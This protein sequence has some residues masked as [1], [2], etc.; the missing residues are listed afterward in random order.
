MGR[1]T[2]QYMGFG[3]M[4]VLLIVLAVGY[5]AIVRTS[6]W[7]FIV[8][9]ALTFFFAN[10]VRPLSWQRFLVSFAVERR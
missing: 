5:D 1:V 10:F 7:I 2:I 6:V 8:L 9:Y 4:S 3:L